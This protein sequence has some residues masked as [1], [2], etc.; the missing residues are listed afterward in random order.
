MPLF[1]KICRE[2]CLY[3]G[4]NPDEQISEFSPYTAF[5]DNNIKKE[6]HYRWKN[7]TILAKKIYSELSK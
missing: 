4:Y 7:F 2:I 1:E 3:Y 5:C 6:L